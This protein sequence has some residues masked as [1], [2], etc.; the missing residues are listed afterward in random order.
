MRIVQFIFLV[1]AL[2]WG[3]PLVNFT[4]NAVYA[5]QA[6]AENDSIVAGN[7]FTPNG[8]GENDF[9]EVKSSNSE[10]VV[11]LKIYT[12]AGVLV[13]SIEARRC[14]WDG[15]TLDGRPMPTGVYFYTAE[16][17]SG[18]GAGTGA[19]SNSSQKISKV[20]FVHLYR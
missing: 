12:R 18:T 20:G 14:V 8:D 6:Q 16:V 17:V 7:V 19:G 1:V 15:Y 2:C 11:A 13:F 10:H 4:G 5:Q 3:S 9:F